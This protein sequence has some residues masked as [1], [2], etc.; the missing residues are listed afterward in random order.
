MDFLSSDHNNT[1][2]AF[3]AQHCFRAGANAFQKWASNSSTYLLVVVAF[4]KF[5]LNAASTES[6]G[7][8]PNIISK[9]AYHVI[10]A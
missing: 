10:S 8:R 7:G 3:V 6:R 2:V 4:P 1:F 9:G 5:V